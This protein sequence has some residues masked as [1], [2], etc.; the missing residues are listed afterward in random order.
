MEELF[1]EKAQYDPEIAK[2]LPNLSIKKI[3]KDRD[4]LYYNFGKIHGLE[5]TA[6]LSREEL[7]A[8]IGNPIALQHA[9]FRRTKEY[10]EKLKK[11]PL[12]NSFEDKLNTFRK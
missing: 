10:R 4:P 3:G 2:R 8:L 9:I 11:E 7:N 6:L 5:N 1:L 12:H